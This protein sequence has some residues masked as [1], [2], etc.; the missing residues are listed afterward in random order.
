MR[1]LH[2]R[3]APKLKRIVEGDLMGKR[4]QLPTTA[5]INAFNSLSDAEKAM[6]FDYIKSQAGA[7]RP[8]SSKPA[9]TAGRRSSSS[10]KLSGAIG[11]SS[12]TNADVAISAAGGD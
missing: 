2:H 7:Q 12:A 9:A 11:V 1:Q 10:N 6:V 5:I 8:K 4:R 3:M